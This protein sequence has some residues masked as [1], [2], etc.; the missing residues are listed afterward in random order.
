MVDRLRAIVFIYFWD[1]IYG[2]FDGLGAGGRSV[3]YNT[4]GFWRELSQRG[5][6]LLC[7]TRQRLD[8]GM[9]DRAKIPPKF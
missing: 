2:I 9:G 5:W 6:G 8:I 1:N 7:L 4:Q 3:I